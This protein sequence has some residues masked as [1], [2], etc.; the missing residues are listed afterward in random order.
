MYLLMSKDMNIAKEAGIEGDDEKEFIV[1]GISLLEV[2]NRYMG[3][4]AVI[5][6]LATNE[7]VGIRKRKRCRCH[8]FARHD[9]WIKGIWSL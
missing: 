3:L 9:L 8:D 5:E 7:L 2:G 4:H 6:V 1:T